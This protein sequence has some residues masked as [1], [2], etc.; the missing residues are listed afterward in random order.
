M[1][2]P[3][4]PAVAEIDPDHASR[5]SLLRGIRTMASLELRL[6]VR[7]GRWRWLLGAWFVLL[8]GFMILLRIALKHDSGGVTYSEI[9]VATERVQRPLGTPMFGG[10]ILFMLGVALLVVPALTAQSVN[11]DRERGV[12]ASLQTTLLSPAQI[13]L[14][15]FVAA[16]GA[17]LVFLL[18]SLPL[19]VWAMSEGGV[20]IGRAVAALAIV[21]LMLGVVVAVAQCLSAIFVRST[22]SAVLSYLFVFAMT[23]GSLI[24]FVLALPA[25][26]TSEQV[27]QRYPVYK[28]FDPSKNLTGPPPIDHYETQTFTEHRTD[29]SKVWWLLAPNPFVVVADAAPRV[30]PKCDPNTGQRLYDPLDPLGTLGNEVR[31]LRVPRD[32]KNAFIVS[33]PHCEKEYFGTYQADPAAG[34]IQLDTPIQIYRPEPVWPW[35][36]GFD[37]LLATGALTITIRRLRAPS[38]KL[39]KGVRIA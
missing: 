28:D 20:T 19:V 25:T 31:K 15:K 9:G 13:A 38:R 35:G 6:R 32:K 39:A 1:T 27:T 11:G 33:G 8:T 10:L 22:T 26:S 16:W 24:T 18:T 23:L 37:V 3:T 34:P 5:L 7:A 4:Q 29:S 17:A 12:L 2:T 14:G 30:A 36:V 21:A